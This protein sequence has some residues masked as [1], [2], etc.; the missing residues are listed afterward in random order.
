M[1]PLRQPLADAEMFF[2]TKVSENWTE[3]LQIIAKE[4]NIVRF[5]GVFLGGEK[6]TVI[7]EGFE[8]FGKEKL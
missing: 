5:T 3:L 1:I 4:T 7:Q 2:N 8:D 6:I